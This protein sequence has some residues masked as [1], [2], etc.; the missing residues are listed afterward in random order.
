MSDNDV[1]RNET[2]DTMQSQALS[3]LAIADALS[4]ADYALSKSS[5]IREPELRALYYGRIETWEY[6]HLFGCDMAIAKRVW[7]NAV[8]H[9]QLNSPGAVK[10]LDQCLPSPTPSK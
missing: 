10:L 5:N 8:Q 3:K 1:E 7:T 2:E 4:R 6:A 9:G